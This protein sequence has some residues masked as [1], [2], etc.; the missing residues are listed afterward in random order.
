MLF[1]F[2]DGIYVCNPAT[3]QRACLPRLQA[4][5][6]AALYAFDEMNG[7][8]DFHIL[9][10]RGQADHKLYYIVDLRALRDMR[11][12]T[13]C[14]GRFASS[15]SLDAALVQGPPPCFNNPPFHHHDNLYW[16]PQM[17]DEDHQHR[18]LVFNTAT[19][20]FWSLAP[21]VVRENV[22]FLAIDGKIAMS[23]SGRGAEAIE[24]WILQDCQHEQWSLSRCIELPVADIANFN[25][26]RVWSATVKTE[27][28]EVLI[29]TPSSVLQYDAKGRYARDWGDSVWPDNVTPHLLRES[30]VPCSIPW[31]MGPAD[32]F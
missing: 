26:A 12:R 29:V 31:T 14:I 21:P 24:I 22:A 10:H 28:G 4:S 11:A 13:R 16:P 30:L 23:A 19:E 7:G 2:F 8:R 1:R 18:I 6:I 27:E 5:E 25:Q 9:Y 17:F 3:H 20:T 15:A 32:W